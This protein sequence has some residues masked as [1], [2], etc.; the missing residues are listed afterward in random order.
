[1][2]FD[3]REVLRARLAQLEQ[4]IV[5]KNQEIA[6]LQKNVRASEVAETPVAVSEFEDTLKRLVQ[7]IAMILQA[8]K[9]AIMILDKE[10]GDLVARTPAFGMS[11][12]DVHMLRVK[13]PEGIAGEVYRSEHPAI[14]HDAINDPRT[15]NEHV[16]ILHI[17]NGVVVPIVVEKRDDENRVLERI[18]IGV[19]SV[20]NKRYGGS[21]IYEDVQLSSRPARNSSA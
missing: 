7:R 8:E 2:S 5:A 17:N 20:F 11:D 15:I 14:F 21:C 3:D 19:L 4:Q 10:S 6:Q 16:A 18:T 12:C 1:M 9:C 13:V